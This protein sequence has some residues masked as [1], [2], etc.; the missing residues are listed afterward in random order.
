MMNSIK[1]ICFWLVPVVFLTGCFSSGKKELNKRV[2][3]WRNDKI[4]YGTWF[5]HEEL[6]HV[7]PYAFIENRSVSPDPN[8]SSKSGKSLI[9][10]DDSTHTL[11]IAIAPSINP[12]SA[13]V[14]AL[15]GFLAKGNHI[16]LSAFRFNQVLLDS[17][18]L[19]TVNSSLNLDD[20]DLL[21][22]TLQHPLEDD[23]SKFQ[24]PGF[25]QHDYFN[26][27]D[28]NTTHV[29]AR[30]S[31]GHAIFVEFQ[32]KSGGTILL[33]TIPLSFSN[34]FLLHQ[35]NK[36]YYDQ[37]FSYLPGNIEYVVWDD[38]FRDANRN[39]YSSSLSAILKQPALRAA[40]YI[41]LLL[42]ALLLFSE[43]K[44][45]QRIV[46]V[47][48][49]LQNSSVDFVTTV[50]RLY[51]QKKDNLDLARK[52]TI[53]FKDYVRNKFGLDT[54]EMTEEFEALLAYKAGYPKADLH[55]L[56]YTI[57][58]AEDF[59]EMT[60]ESLMALAEQLDKFYKNK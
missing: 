15:S 31:G 10:A 22:F 60:D 59:Q 25:G 58:M 20:D 7:F 49:P 11:F 26:K 56:L 36:R 45:R 34:F 32:M 13:E 18:G 38:Y 46:P 47:I 3:L 57:R 12:D 52:M 29:L 27:Y 33:N 6:S 21:Q 4:P 44:R 35:S 53:H 17:L 40:F 55:Q 30:D 8:H 51:L 42:A 1:H 39:H 48:Q 37:V 9:D 43:I 54:A 5:A 50:G 23:T 19:S 14:E 24:Y 28:T 16:F 2:T 41:V